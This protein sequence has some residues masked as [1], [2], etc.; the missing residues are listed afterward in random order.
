[1]WL[2]E[3]HKYCLDK[4]KKKKRTELDFSKYSEKIFNY[5]YDLSKD[6]SNFRVWWVHILMVSLSE[7][8]KT[9]F[10]EVLLF[11]WRISLL[12]SKWSLKF[13]QSPEQKSILH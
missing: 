8:S 12:F 4:Q 11:V 7:V 9:S 6:I 10:S 2:P 3:H 13:F 1:M 5:Q